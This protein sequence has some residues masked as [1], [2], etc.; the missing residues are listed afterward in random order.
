MIEFV[1]YYK[2]KGHIFGQCMS[3]TNIDLMYINIPKNASSWTKPN[4]LDWDWE[5]YNYHNDNLYHKKAIVP[6]RDPVDRWLSGISEYLFLYHK[7]LKISDISTS[8]LDLIFDRIAFDD[9]TEKQSLFLAGLN[10]SNCIFLYVDNTYRDKFSKLLAYNNMPNSYHRYEYQ[11]TTDENLVKKN[12]KEFFSVKINENKFYL[13]TLK[14]Y[15]ANDY[16]LINSVQF[17]D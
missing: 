8:Y 3:K 6:L 9:H 2:N 16:H 15:F 12:I 1:E 17:Y 10:L 14:S 4:L 13:N 11:Y 7:D 5:F